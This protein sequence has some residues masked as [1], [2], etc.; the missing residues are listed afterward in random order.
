MS[1]KELYETY[2]LDFEVKLSVYACGQTFEVSL[3]DLGTPKINYVEKKLVFDA[4]YN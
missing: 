1:I 4:E 3:R 2:D